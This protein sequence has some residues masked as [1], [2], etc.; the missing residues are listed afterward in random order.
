MVYWA[1]APMCC[2]MNHVVG[3][4]NITA[5]SKA[6]SS[7]NRFI[8]AKPRGICSVA[9]I[10]RAF[11]VVRLSRKAISSIITIAVA[12]CIVSSPTV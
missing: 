8:I 11:P 2:H 5:K 4:K 12:Q 9:P 10:L 6:P 1:G 7:P 3:I